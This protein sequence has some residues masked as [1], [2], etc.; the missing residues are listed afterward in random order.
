MKHDRPAEKDAHDLRRWFKASFICK[1]CL[2]LNPTAG[3]RLPELSFTAHNLSAGW[4][5][6]CIDHA[7]YMAHE[8]N[9]SPYL[10]LIRGMTT[11]ALFD[12]FMYDGYLG[13]SGTHCAN[14][15][16]VAA[17]T[18]VGILRNRTSNI[19]IYIYIYIYNA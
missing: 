14:H 17:E 4:I 9:L 5:S 3:V 13:T 19:Y 1:K 8:R 6:T 18:V 16:A 11:D 15:F 7:T 2:A 12:D 10:S